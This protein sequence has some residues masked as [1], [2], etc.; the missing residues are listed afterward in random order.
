MA[1]GSLSCLGCRRQGL[2]QGNDAAA[3]SRRGRSFERLEELCL[4][5]AGTPP[6]TFLGLFFGLCCQIVGLPKSNP[7]QIRLRFFLHKE[8]LLLVGWDLSGSCAGKEAS[9]PLPFCELQVPKDW[10]CLLTLAAR[11]VLGNCTDV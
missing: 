2:A 4:K 1:L 8:L 5:A 9:A 6:A 3:G 11:A 10:H 7:R